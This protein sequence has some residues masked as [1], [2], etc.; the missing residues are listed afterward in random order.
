MVD[1]SLLRGENCGLS[2]ALEV[3]GSLPFFWVGVGI[4]DFLL[5]DHRIVVEC[6]AEY[7]SEIVTGGE[8]RLFEILVV[9]Q[10]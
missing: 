6:F 8:F 1:Y 3:E 7:I 2:A 4:V 5:Q 9:E 10:Q